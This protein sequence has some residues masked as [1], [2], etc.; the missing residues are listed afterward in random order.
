MASK[1]NPWRSLRS[2]AVRTRPSQPYHHAQSTIR[3]ALPTGRRGLT[4]DTSIRSPPDGADLPPPSSA[5]ESLPYIE[6]FAD[7]FLNA[8]ALA[9]LEKA[10]SGEDA[11]SLSVEGLKYGMPTPP[12]KHEQLQDRH[13][14]VIH[15]VTRMLMR[16][17]KLS[18]A[19]Q[20]LSFI[21][22]YLRTSP[23]PKVSPLRPLLP[24]SPPPHQLPLNP[25]LYLTLAID[26]VAPVVRIRSLKGIAS[27]GQNL[28]IPVPIDS[29]ARRRMA[30]QWVLDIV[31]KKRSTGSGRKQFAARFGAE[32]VAVIEGRSA[33][34]DRRQIIH[35]A[36]TASRA[37][38]VHPAL[39]SGK[40]KP[41]SKL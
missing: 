1:L 6:P 30:I 19:Q 3:A 24:G 18:A 35:K 41:R 28:D 26:S 9:A 21:L 27:G 2:L 32:I 7:N 37:N 8:E 22:N 40:R 38:L 16:D 17:G 10:A 13:H 33:A 31:T 5:K 12:A 34:W 15:Q 4:N 14:P 36:A 29:R 11:L 39:L 23:P 20:H 25:L